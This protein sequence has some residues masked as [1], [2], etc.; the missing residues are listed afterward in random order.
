[1]AEIW[2]EIVLEVLEAVAEEIEEEVCEE[3]GGGKGGGTEGDH[4]LDYTRGG[5]AGGDRGRV[6]CRRLYINKVRERLME[7][8]AFQDCAPA[9]SRGRSL[10]SYHLRTPV[11]WK[12]RDSRGMTEMLCRLVRCSRVFIHGLLQ[13]GTV[14]AVALT[15]VYIALGGQRSGGGLVEDGGDSGDGFVRGSHDS[16]RDFIS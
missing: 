14:L 11:F 12:S 5:R 6:L 3:A 1:M 7:V 10:A 8:V 13:G 2:E 4:G 9:L 16:G 15:R